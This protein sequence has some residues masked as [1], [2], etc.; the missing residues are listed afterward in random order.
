[1]ISAGDDDLKVLKTKRFVLPF[2]SGVVV[3]KH[4]LIHN[5]IRADL[6]KETL[7]K[8]EKSKLGLN[9]NG[10]YTELREGVSELKQIEAPNWLKN[11][12]Q[13]ALRTANVP[14]TLHRI[15]KDRLGKDSKYNAAS[16]AL[17]ENSLNAGKPTAPTAPD[18]HGQT[19]ELFDYFISEFGAN[20]SKEP[21]TFTW[22]RC[23][24]TVK[25]Y[26]KKFGLERMKMMITAYFGSNDKFYSKSGWSLQVFLMDTVLH[27]LSVK[28][29]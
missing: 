24:K 4:W 17:Q 18:Y 2:E 25:P 11:R 9:D 10:A 29:K 22:G 8:V 13:E 23:E 21:P 28:T 6:Y 12:R 16:A 19:K 3:I 1:M 5:L 26:L 7:H 20:I 27:S 14:Q 15:G